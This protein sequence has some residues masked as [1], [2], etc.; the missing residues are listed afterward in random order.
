V[1]TDPVCGMWVDE[2]A[3]SLQL[4][5]DNRSYYFCS[6]S[7]L[8]LFSQPEEEQRRLSL[9]LAVA[10]PLSVIVLVLTYAVGASTETIAASAVLATIVQV[11]AGIP[12]YLGSRDALRERTWNMDVLIAVG[13]TAAYVYSLAA[14]LLPARLPHDY[15]FDA[16]SLILTLIL[17]GNFLEHF[18]RGR[19]GSALRR[20]HELIPATAG[21][22]R[23]GHEV[24]VPVAEVGVGDRLRVRPGGRFPVDAVIRAGRTSVDESL[25]TGESIPVAKGPGDRVLAA[26]INGEGAV[27][28]EA[29][30]IGS[31]TFVAEVGRLLTESEMARVPLKRTADRIAAAFVPTVLILALASGAFWFVLGGAGA[32]VALLV[33]VTVT[34]I[35]CPCA[36]GIATPAAIIVGTGRAA[37]EGILFRGEDVLQQ[38]A[39]VDLVLTDKTGTL[40]R[41]RP[42]LAEVRTL[43]GV[44]ESEVLG[45]AAAVEIG[46]EH[47]LGRAVVDAARQRNLR[48]LPAEGIRADPGYGIR[49]TVEGHVVEV[50]RGPG[51]LGAIPVPREW[52]GAL[53]EI[54]AEG[55]SSSVVT[56]NAAIVGILGFSDAV[57][58][59]VA[60]AV[61]ALHRDGVGV[62]MVTG[63]SD[64][65]AQAVARQ[66]GI[67]EV[68]SR[69]SPA[70]KLDLIRR[71]RSAGRHV[72]Y[73]GDGIN[74]APALAGADLG[75][76]I[77]SGTDV[78]RESGGVVLVRS[79]F[80]GVAF[81]LR[82]ARRTVRKVRDNLAW[83]IG[84]NLILLP[85]AMGA[86][87]PLLGVSVYDVLP[88]FAAIAMGLSST[89]VVLNSVSLRWV[90]LGGGPAAATETA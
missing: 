10:W 29:V 58:P 56:K 76:A 21:V 74:D 3:S 12:F 37:E 85:V 69:M 57:A 71:F 49:G 78:A 13:T 89:I 68:H 35:A 32:T 26:S 23:D 75:I 14:F 36:F 9:R 27:E 66:V 20:L 2:R 42:S 65:V 52:A 41:G 82:L 16:S 18:T 7:C 51:T 55:R 87:V 4:I 25:L 30:T 59:G 90:T 88:I 5:R 43:T 38:A 63:D 47:P 79:D 28:V 70:E 34:V 44:T 84:Y 50:L 67:S 19:A 61:K 24:E 39:R 33:F 83:A 45:L 40:T 11:Y 54:E 60:D 17:T 64:T 22:L 1:A 6:E 81:A 62:V 77:G 53:A 73:V 15:Y 86:L 46:S 8:H 48:L 80:R 31:D 72:A